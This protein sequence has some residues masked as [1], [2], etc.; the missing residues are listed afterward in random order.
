VYGVV[1]IE[2]SENSEINK[3]IGI[4]IEIDDKDRLFQEFSKYDIKGYFFVK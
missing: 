3:V 2:S 1:R 4:R